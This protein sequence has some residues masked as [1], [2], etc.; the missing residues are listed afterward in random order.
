MDFRFQDNTLTEYI[1]NG[2]ILSLINYGDFH[3]HSIYSLH[4]MASS[5]ELVK[6]ANDIGLK[7]LA[8]TDHH[9]PYEQ[10]TRSLA[11]YDINDQ[12]ISLRDEVSKLFMNNQVARLSCIKEYFNGYQPTTVIPGY[13]YNL[14][15]GEINSQYDSISHLR[16]IGLHSWFVPK[17]VSLNSVIIDIANQL[18]YQK[19]QIF[20][21]PEREIDLTGAS[22][23][24]DKEKFLKDIVRI[25]R[26]TNT[27]LELNTG[28]LSGKQKKKN[29]KYMRIWLQ[30][31]KKN[32][33]RIVVNSDSHSIYTIGSCYEG[34]ELLNSIGYPIDLIANFDEE[35]IKEFLVK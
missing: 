33:N 1:N 7:Y 3:T 10:F 25:C 9:Y 35:F 18:T 11:D 19:Y 16:L 15:K 21:H 12:A 23:E 8:I 4:G 22:D 20:V 26:Q 29:L 30:E 6:R 13:E 2:Q 27:L 24:K 28:S 32:N 34:F 14:F 31:A 5:N 17:D